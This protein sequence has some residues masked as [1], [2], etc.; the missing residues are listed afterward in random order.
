M[1]WSFLQCTKLTHLSTAVLMG[2][3]GNI[4]PYSSDP[5]FV[6]TKNLRTDDATLLSTVRSFSLERLDKRKHVDGPSSSR[7]MDLCVSKRKMDISPSDD[8]LCK[9]NVAC[10]DRVD[11]EREANATDESNQ[12]KEGNNRHC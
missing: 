6:S 1:L 10:P 5:N 2:T 12:Q 9:Y 8:D 3:T 7:G 11:S 4:T